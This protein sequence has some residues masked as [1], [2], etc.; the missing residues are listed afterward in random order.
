[1]LSVVGGWSNE[2]EIN[3]EMAVTYEDVIF[4]AGRPVVDSLV[5]F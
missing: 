2:N 3:N 4:P 5:V 1:M